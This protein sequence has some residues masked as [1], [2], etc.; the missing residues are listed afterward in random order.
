MKLPRSIKLP[1]NATRRI[2]QE[3]ARPPETKPAE[4]RRM[5]DPAKRCIAISVDITFHHDD[6][7]GLKPGGLQ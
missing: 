6:G 4:P 3:T 2:P 7:V 1:A 5:L